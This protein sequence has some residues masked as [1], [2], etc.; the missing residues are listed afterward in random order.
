MYGDDLMNTKKIPT[1]IIYVLRRIMENGGE[2]YIVGGALRNYLLDR[3]IHDWDIATSLLPNEI[4]SAFSDM[5]TVTTGKKFGTITVFIDGLQVEVTTYRTEED[6]RDYRHPSKVEFT[7]NIYEDLKRRDFTMNA[8]AL[9]PLFQDRTFIDPFNGHRDIKLGIIRAVGNPH[10]RFSEDPLRMMRAIRFMSQ[11]GF[12]IDGT[13]MNSIRYNSKIITKI[14]AERIKDELE[15]TLLGKFVEKGIITLYLS[16]IQNYI[17]P[18]SKDIVDE[19]IIERIA[20]SIAKCRQDI[21]ERFCAYF[22]W[23]IKLENRTS[24]LNKI[25]RRLRFDNK[26]RK[27]IIT[28][29]SYIDTPIGKRM[30]AYSLRRLMGE[31]GIENTLRMLHLMGIF[32]YNHE[33]M[34]KLNEMASTIIMEEQ[35]IYKSE[36]DLDGHDL[37]DMGIGVKDPRDI[38]HALDI[39]YD[40]ILMD[41]KLNDKEIL[42]SRL[43]KYYNINS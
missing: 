4:E 20:Y 7:Q 10:A 38:G 21:I 36:L 43:R 5:H 25:L 8:L 30:P 40:W 41:P 17:I 1:E 3:P 31:M 15:Q 6:Y 19:E 27:D 33:T 12:T 24:M 14:P 37:I 2:A 42:L 11:L 35:P 18:E 39:A 34:C 13:T 29:I 32:G 26:T 23:T 16:G 22:I 28:I 9:N